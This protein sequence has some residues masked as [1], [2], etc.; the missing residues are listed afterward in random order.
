VAR[1]FD[2]VV[3]TLGRTEELDRFLTALERQGDVA[4][5]VLVVDQNDHD[6]VV[7][8]LGRHPSIPSLRLRSAPGLSRARNVALP[9]LEADVVG[10]PDDDCLYPDGLLER[11]AGILDGR[12][13]LDGVTGQ[14]ADPHGLPSGRWPTTGG[15]LGLETLWNR[16]ISYTIFLRR[17][18]LQGLHGFDVALGLGSG[19]PWHSGEEIELL[20]RA[21]RAGARI[22][23]DP[24]LVV[25]HPARGTTPDELEALGRRDGASLGWILA[26]HDYPARVV[27]RMLARPVGGAALGLVRRDG[28][29][30]RFH[31]A[32]LR[33]RLA[34]YR[35]GR[36]AGVVADDE[37]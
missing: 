2:L 9:L 7:V 18:V 17:P 24:T 35:A 1:T 21:L 8:V 27:A 34:G 4:V 10:F 29:R 3:A 11:V 5:R 13:G 19:T 26:R 12:P 36:R 28:A 14:S 30:T 20:V 31:V 32:T 22:D 25:I 37:L 6:D 33:G 15:P 16:A 23:Y